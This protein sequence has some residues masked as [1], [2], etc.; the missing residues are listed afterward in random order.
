MLT[1]D[2]ITHL[3]HR[4]S[5]FEDLEPPLKAIKPILAFHVLLAQDRDQ[6]CGRPVGYGPDR[7]I[8]LASVPA[9]LAPGIDDCHR[10]R[11]NASRAAARSDQSGHAAYRF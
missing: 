11:G 6:T 1:H 5:P 2:L 8:L 10:G 7:R 9:S 4:H 3:K